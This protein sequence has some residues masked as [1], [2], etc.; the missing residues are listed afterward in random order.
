MNDWSPEE[1]AAA[2]EVV[3]KM[4]VEKSTLYVEDRGE[5]FYLDGVEVQYTAMRGATELSYAFDREVAEATVIGLK[6]LEMKDHDMYLL[7]ARFNILTGPLTALVN[8]LQG[9]SII[10][11]PGDE[12]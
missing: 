12:E 3:A 2:E 7:A 6:L 10:Q 1:R 9:K 4:R 5:P 11:P 8:C